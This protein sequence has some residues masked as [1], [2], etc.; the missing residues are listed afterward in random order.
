MKWINSPLPLRPLYFVIGSEAFFISEIKN[1]FLKSMNFPEGAK[2]FNHDEVSAE[3]LSADNLLNLWETL[4]FLSERRLIFCR[5]A[6]KFSER[7]WDKLTPLLTSAP[8]S[9]TLVLFFNKKD[10]RRKHF[11]MLQKQAQELSAESLRPWEIKDWL[12]FISKRENLSFSEEARALFYQLVGSNLME[13]QLELKKL[14]DYKGDDK[15]PL[16]EK[17][18]LS[19]T[20]RLKTEAVFDFTSAVGKKDIVRALSS[21]AHLLDQN[22]NEIGVL[23][24]VARHIRILSKLKEGKKENLNKNQ[25]AKKAG[26]SPYFLKDYLVQIPLWPEPQIHRA[27]ESLLETDKALK[28]SPLSSHIWLENFVIKTCS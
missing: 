25:L 1:T 13:I 16:S 9:A 10:A 18:I 15:K 8:E 24:M 5:Q 11:K 7:D 22:E 4:P 2:D 21:L 20:S 19:C 28:S 3:S 6:E 12:D 14:K 17:D 23:A 27:M 26:I